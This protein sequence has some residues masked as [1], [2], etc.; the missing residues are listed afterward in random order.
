MEKTPKEYF[1]KVDVNKFTA[2]EIKTAK[3]VKAEM[4]SGT[5]PMPLISIYMAGEICMYGEIKAQSPMCHVFYTLLC[6]GRFI[7]TKFNL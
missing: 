2:E 7:S 6:A 3:A 4:L 5:M 1:V